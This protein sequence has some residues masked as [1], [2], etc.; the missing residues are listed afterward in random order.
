ML[1]NPFPVATLVFLDR[2]FLSPVPA[3]ERGEI[4]G[5]EGFSVDTDTF[6]LV[7]LNPELDG[8]GIL[9]IFDNLGVTVEASFQMEVTATLEILDSTMVDGQPE[10]TELD[11]KVLAP[12]FQ[13]SLGITVHDGT[14]EIE[15]RLDQH[16]LDDLAHFIR[17]NQEISSINYS[18][19][20]SEIT[21]DIEMIAWSGGQFYLLIAITPSCRFVPQAIIELINVNNE[22]T[23]CYPDLKYLAINSASRTTATPDRRA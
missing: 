14:A 20:N 10:I 12:Q 16:W 9:L 23:L 8:G 2:S 18:Y 3:I 17:L 4:E 22:T 19:S 21:L 7:L 11:D 5:Q 6:A 1:G 13:G 15:Q